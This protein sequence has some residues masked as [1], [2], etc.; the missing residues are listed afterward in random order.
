VTDRIWM[1]V[2]WLWT[3]SIREFAILGG[4]GGPGRLTAET[5][6]EYRPTSKYQ[7]FVPF[8]Q[9]EFYAQL[10]EARDAVYFPCPAW[11][12]ESWTSPAVL[13][14]L[15]PVVTSRTAMLLS[16]KAETPESNFW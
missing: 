5:W 14:S 12:G 6:T 7:A 4:T 8:K 11:R 1:A 10:G 13:V 16:G 3:A 15:P 9:V 2:A